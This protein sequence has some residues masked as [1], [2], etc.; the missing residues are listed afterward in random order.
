M[1]ELFPESETL[2]A[3]NTEIGN[4]APQDFVENS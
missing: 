3:G 1:Q 4:L 2:V